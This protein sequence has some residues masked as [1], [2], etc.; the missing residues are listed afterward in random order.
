[1]GNKVF[2]LTD[3]GVK[4]ISEKDEMLLMAKLAFQRYQNLT[5][6]RLIQFHNMR[7]YAAKAGEDPDMF[8]I[9]QCME[10]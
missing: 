10:E 3:N 6:E 7:K 9:K 5:K 8:F 2:L 4:Q 1:M